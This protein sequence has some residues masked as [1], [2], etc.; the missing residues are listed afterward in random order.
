M[1]NH[2]THLNAQ[3]SIEYKN[4]LQQFQNKMHQKKVGNLKAETI[5]RASDKWQLAKWT[6]RARKLRERKQNVQRIEQ[7]TLPTTTVTT[8]QYYYS[9]ILNKNNP[10]CLFP[11]RHTQPFILFSSFY[12]SINAASSILFFVHL[13]QKLFHR[14]ENTCHFHFPF[15]LLHF[16]WMKIPQS[17]AIHLMQPYFICYSSAP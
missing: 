4:K 11:L 16:T 8:S 12:T 1:P 10:V 3:T 13:I 5:S 2:S 17:L 6:N 14:L 15:P 7:P 9:P